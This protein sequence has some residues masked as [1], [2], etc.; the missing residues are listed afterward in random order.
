[1]ASRTALHA[2]ALEDRL[3]LS[4]SPRL[5]LDINP[6]GASSNA[7]QFTQVNNSAFFSADD[8]IHGNE[9]WVTN[10]SDTGTSLVRD[11]NPG[12][13]GFYPDFLTNVNGTL[14]FG[15][16][17]GTHGSE[18]WKSNGTAAG[19]SMVVDL[20]PGPLSSY[21]KY[22][23]NFSGTLFFSANDGTHGV[24]LWESNGSAAGTFLVEDI[25][26]GM[27]GSYPRYLTNVNGT[28]FFAA[29]DGP[30][31][32]ALWRSNGSAAGTSMVAD[33]D[34]VASGSGVYHDS[35]TN[36]N[37]TLFFSA[38]DGTHGTE[39]WESNGTAA[40][41]SMVADINPGPHNSY[42]K[43]LTNFSGT[44]FFSAND[45]THGA[46]LWE[47]NGTAA[48]TSMVEDINP[49][50]GGSYPLFLTNCGFLFF[51]ADDGSHGRELW[52]IGIG[53]PFLDFDVNPGPVGSYP[54]Y[55]TNVNGTLFFRA[56]DGT[57]GDELWSVPRVST[58]N[59]I[60]PGPTGSYP[61]DLT[62]VNGALFFT[63][64][65]GTFGTEPWIVPANTDFLASLSIQSSANPSVFGQ[66]VTF[67]ASIPVGP[68]D[69]TPTGTVDFQEGATDL[70]PGGVNLTDGQATFSTSA[71]GIG[72]HTISASYSGDGNFSPEAGAIAS[73][74]VNEN[75]TATTVFASPSTLVSGQAAALA[76]VVSNT[77]GPFGTP[78]GTVQ[79]AVDGTNV[80]APVPLNNGVATL[81][82]RL[83]ASGG[84]HTITATYINSDGNFVG[85]SGSATQAV[86][87]D[88]TRTILASSPTT[89]VAGQ[90]VVFTAAVVP[91][92]PGTGTP[93]GTVD[94]KD[95][96]TDLTPGGITLSAGRAFFSTSSLGLG[97]H[98]ITASYSGDVNFTG[99][100]ANDGSAPEVVNQASTRTV[101]TSFP[102][103]AV[104]GQVVSFT[105][106]VLALAPSQGTPT[107][108]VAFS[109]GSTTIG[110]VTLNN[111]GRAT[112]TTAS[113]SRGNH[114]IN[115]SYGG[116]SNFLVSS[117]G[118]F[119]EGVQHDGTTTTLAAKVNSAVVGTTI[120]FTAQVQPNSPGAGTATGTVTFKDVTTVLGTGA[121]NSTGQATFSTAALAVGTHAIT[122][123][124]P[125]S[126]RSSRHPWRTQA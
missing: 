46:E 91:L 61:G 90:V 112:F 99:S 113:L 73:Q 102:D 94:F 8:G 103:P 50:S 81:P 117:D 13:A 92:A 60:N 3:L 82:D 89:A 5:L 96:A 7:G 41:T 76:A 70:T 45:G 36:V 2:E 23:T 123:S 87:E 98:T 48:G 58:I 121:L 18:L 59:D 33:I 74:V 79:F 78:T 106:A 21:L 100:S 42:P 6:G 67:T 83:S 108:T 88:S 63:A 54:Q 31:S 49:G 43:Y 4:Q 125:S 1:M 114:S 116:D 19:T 28:L 71:L 51:S 20:T 57:H 27:S 62:N 34:P 16:R 110:S 12:S 95:G 122:A 93:T 86:S 65:D 10:G 55:L 75:A 80:G 77:S 107:G 11:I 52:G 115:A 25:N 24:E 22:L 35:L 32:R 105:V 69:P 85:G 37:G 118:N 66:G 126:P 38:N 64:N 109:D 53:S 119:G 15:A 120:T 68:G 40:G 104:F 17:D 47:S 26:P 9:L 39:L 29:N 44:L 84:P 101:M 14:F 30:D 56:N 72:S 124:R 97:K 111:V